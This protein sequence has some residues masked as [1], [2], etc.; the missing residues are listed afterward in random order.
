M[1]AETISAGSLV[2][3]T[4]DDISPHVGIGAIY[5][6]LLTGHALCFITGSL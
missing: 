4:Y 3:R 2:S 5:M 6:Q 1:A